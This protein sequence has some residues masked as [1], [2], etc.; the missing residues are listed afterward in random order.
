MDR[1]GIGA[2]LPPWELEPC[3]PPMEDD[4]DYKED[5]NKYLRSKLN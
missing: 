3:S 4:W 1:T 2:S 5:I